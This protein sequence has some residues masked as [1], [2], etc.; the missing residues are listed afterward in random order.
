MNIKDKSGHAEHEVNFCTSNTEQKVMFQGKIF[1]NF[2]YLKFSLFAVK[3]ITIHTGKETW[4]IMKKD[5]LS[6]F[7]RI[8]GLFQLH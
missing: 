7:I 1:I 8:T 2:N 6:V 4:I 5:V 3:N